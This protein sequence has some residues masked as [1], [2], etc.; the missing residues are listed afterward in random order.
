MTL[1]KRISLILLIIGYI[2]AGINHFRVPDFYVSIIPHYIRN[3]QLMNVLAGAFEIIFGVGLIFKTTCKWA[4]WGIV[5]MLIA[6]LPVHV[7]MITSQPFRVEG[8]VV[9]PLLSWTRL[10]LQPALILWVWWHTHE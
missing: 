7:S 4:A 1:T 8:A 5:L 2:A 6:F 3:A 10:A 9:S